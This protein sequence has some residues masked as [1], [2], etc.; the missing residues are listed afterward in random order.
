MNVEKKAKH[1]QISA[2]AAIAIAITLA[3]TNIGLIIGIPL[4][5]YGLYMAA[6]QNKCLCRSCRAML[7]IT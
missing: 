3:F 7:Q 6:A 1:N 4:G 2:L 5:L